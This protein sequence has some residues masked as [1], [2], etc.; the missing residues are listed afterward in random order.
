VGG[1]VEMPV[2]G[3]GSHSQN[4]TQSGN[5]GINAFGLTLL[6]LAGI[7]VMGGA[8]VWVVRKR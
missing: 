5:N 2:I 6:V 8:T 3:G 1:F 7:V 4:N